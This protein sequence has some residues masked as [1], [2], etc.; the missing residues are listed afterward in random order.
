MY[1]FY[2]KNKKERF[3]TSKYPLGQSLLD[4]IY[5]D[6]GDITRKLPSMGT[7]V[8]KIR[9]GQD[10]EANIRKL[11]EFAEELPSFHEYFS[12][13]ALK[14]K[15]NIE[16]YE[17]NGKISDIRTIYNNIVPSDTTMFSDIIQRLDIDKAVDLSGLPD[18]NIP[19]TTL[20]VRKGRVVEVVEPKTILEIL[21]YFAAYFLKNGL[22]FR[23][24]KSCGLYFPMAGN[25]KQEYCTR[26]MES[27]TKRCNELGALK[28]YQKK[29]FAQDELKLY[30][31][32]Y[33]TRFSRIKAGKLTKEDFSAWSEKARVLRDM[34][35]NEVIEIN[36]LE[37]WLSNN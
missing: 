31:T 4:Y 3:E 36:A 14:I 20:T 11:R 19:E 27:S 30:N 23:I 15:N 18:I 7:A 35:S 25:I 32:A 1:K 13:L 2:V 28:R 9:S 34:C 6:F 17:Q 24:C 26:L 33:K 12:L 5:G 10:V 22:K 29:K 8:K 16:E 21:N 37:D